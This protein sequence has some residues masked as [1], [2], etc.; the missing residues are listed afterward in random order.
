MLDVRSE[1]EQTIAPALEALPG[2]ANVSGCGG[3]KRRS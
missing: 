1:L 3:E 2:A